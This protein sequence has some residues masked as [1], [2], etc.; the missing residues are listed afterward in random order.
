[1]MRTRYG[2]GTAGAE[3]ATGRGFDD[4][5]A[6]NAGTDFCGATGTF[7]CKMLFESLTLASLAGCV[8]CAKKQ[9]TI[10]T[11]A[12]PAVTLLRKSPVLLTPRV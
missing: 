3:G 11:V 8:N 10:T 5:A 12:R 1:M 2:A 6:G 9:A 4:G 7:F